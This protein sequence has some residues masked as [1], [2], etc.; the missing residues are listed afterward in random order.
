MC[1]MFSAEGMR[2]I[3]EDAV[4]FIFFYLFSAF[5]I[6]EIHSAVTQFI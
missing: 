3:S 4:P 6:Q 1:S 5:R 2:F